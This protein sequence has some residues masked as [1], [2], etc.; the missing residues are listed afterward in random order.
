[1]PGVVVRPGRVR[2]LHGDG[3]AP[4]A[5]AS[6]AWCERDPGGTSL[7]VR[8]TPTIGLA[9]KRASGAIRRMLASWILAWFVSVTPR[10]VARRRYAV[11]TTGR[12]I[13]PGWAIAVRHAT[14][15][16]IRSVGWAARGTPPPST[17]AKSPART[18]DG[19]LTSGGT[20]FDSVDTGQSSGVGTS[21]NRPGNWTA[22]E[23]RRSAASR[24]TRY[25][26]ASP[27]SSAPAGSAGPR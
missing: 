26:P 13:E 12:P 3:I 1:M 11:A 20:R 9:W 18:S 15:S 2:P 25:W 24:S 17:V 16:D 23:Y 7:G 6:L 10:P 8:V 4:T 21:R 14:S 19:S 5:M 27:R 22:I